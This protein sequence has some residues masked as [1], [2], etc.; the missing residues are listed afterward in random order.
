MF[1]GYWL[2]N[3]IC[4]VKQ[5]DKKEYYIELNF[6]LDSVKLHISTI[7]DNKNN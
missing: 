3:N 1:K 6:S 4:Q 5:N 7:S 2:L